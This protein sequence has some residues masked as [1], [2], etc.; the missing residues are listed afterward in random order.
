MKEG[1]KTKTK[2]QTAKKSLLWITESKAMQEIIKRTESKPDVK[3]TC[4]NMRCILAILS[5]KVE[6]SKKIKRKLAFNFPLI[7]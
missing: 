5:S 1:K 7:D 3:Y 4:A 6:G 2:R